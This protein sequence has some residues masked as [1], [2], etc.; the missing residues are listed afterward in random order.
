MENSTL[1]N[2]LW[3]GAITGISRAAGFVRDFMIAKFLGAGA[4]ADAFFMAFK[5]PNLFRSIFAEGA[6][7]SVFVP[8]FS[9][10]MQAEGERGAK[11]LSRD[12]FAF[13]FYMVL[14]MT[15]VCELAMPGIVWL[16]APGFSA[17]P[18]KMA[19]TVSLARITFPFMAFV[20]VAS[21]FGGIL[22]SLGIFK[23]YAISPIIL[24][25]V[26]IA[27]AAMGAGTGAAHWLAWGVAVAGVI[28][29]VMLWWIAARY[30]FGTVSLSMNFS[31]K[32]GTFFRNLGPGLIGAGIYHINILIGTIFATQENGATSW[33]YYAD[34]LN[35]LPIGI[36]GVAVATVMLPKL[37]RH[38]KL[39]E[40][41]EARSSFNRSL[42][43]AGLVSIPAAFALAGFAL[44]LFEVFFE[45]GLFTHF[46]SIA[47]ARALVVLCAGMPALVF[48]KQ[49]VNV[50]YARGDTK[51]P[52]L[53]SLA[54]MLANLVLT[55]ILHAR[56]AYI[57]I[58]ASVTVT[59]WLLLAILCI[60]AHTKGL[61]E[62]YPV[63]V[64]AL[65]LSALA[66]MAVV[67][68]A[69]LVYGIMP[70]ATFA[71]KFASL[72]AVGLAATAVYSAAAYLI[73]DLGKRGG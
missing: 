22:N 59:S 56:F 72:A 70:S 42:V 50:F 5:I 64:K 62:I 47:S 39:G 29:L 16:V 6:F 30:G 49:I 58:V 14:V 20:A 26:L 71:A 9:G 69:V 67:G 57:G 24:N 13:L 66:S 17:D 15:L 35:Q 65:F 8:L 3:V 41:R 33:I 2:S 51:T 37:S 73:V 46:D 68:G 43:F 54:S 4:V 38:A 28:Q 25:L 63:T 12:I 19:L 40:E 31:P 27:A 55:A 52:M 11:R 10:A 34:R 21:F 45:R 32:V 53:A 48:T 44:P 61:M 18:A 23:P 36:V 7:A 60:L 1:K